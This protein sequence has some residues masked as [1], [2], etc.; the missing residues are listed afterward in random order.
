MKMPHGAAASAPPDLSQRPRKEKKGAQSPSKP[1]ASVPTSKALRV[2]T[3]PAVV[4]KTAVIST[5]QAR[6][7]PIPVSS[8]MPT[9]VASV[10]TLILPP[11]TMAKESTAEF[12]SPNSPRPAASTGASAATETAPPAAPLTRSILKE[13]EDKL[14]LLRDHREIFEWVLEKQSSL[15]GEFVSFLKKDLREIDYVVSDI[16]NQGDRGDFA[17]NALEL[18]KN[19]YIKH[20]ERSFELISPENLLKRDGEKE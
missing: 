15:R 12:S 8:S 17:S 5:G 3:A 16:N 4:K 18:I 14:A 19:T 2:E 10:P 1:K 6:D 13:A 7:V 11:T 20:W 9:G